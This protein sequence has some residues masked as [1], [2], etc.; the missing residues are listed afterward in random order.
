MSNS[1]NH[2]GVS[3][4]KIGIENYTTF[5]LCPRPRKRSKYYQYD[6]RDPQHGLFL[7]SR[8]NIRAMSRK[9]RLVAT[10]QTAITHSGA[11]FQY[12][13]SA[14]FFVSFRRKKK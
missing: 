2:N 10:I 11:T 13:C 12:S 8:S 1:I 7:G 5:N 6:F 14:T 9:T 4:C 3:T